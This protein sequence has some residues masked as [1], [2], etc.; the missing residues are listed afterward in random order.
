MTFYLIVGAV[1]LFTL[2]VQGTLRRTYSR[3]SRVR[4]SAGLP[5]SRVARTIL[6]A[7]EM[8]AVRVEPVRGKLSDHYDPR[9]KVIRLSEPIYERPS[10]ASLAISAHESGHA[11]QDHLHYGPLKFRTAV[12][13]VANFAARFGIPA[14]IGG[15]L[16]DMIWLVQAGVVAYVGALLMQFLTLPVE[17]NASRRALSQLEDLALMSESETEGARKVLRAAAMTYVAGVASAAGY[18]VYLLLAGGRMILRK[19]PAAPPSIP[20]SGPAGI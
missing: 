10:V 13:P 16:L 18:I 17:F 12:A 8:R 15:A 2:L 11:L 20:P 6:N 19:P 7:N 4:N 1:F 9:T 5:G 14:L 3:W